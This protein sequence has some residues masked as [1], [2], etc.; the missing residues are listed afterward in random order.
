MS[1]S[2]ERDLQEH[3]RLKMV[4]SLGLGAASLAMLA[5]CSAHGGQSNSAGI[6]ASAVRDSN[7]DQEEALTALAVGYGFSS[8]FHILGSLMLTLASLYISPLF[9]EERVLLGSFTHISA[10]KEAVP[11]AEECKT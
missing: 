7:Q 11:V 2:A 3:V 6:Q 8:F 4:I 5:F 10:R 9:T 1:E